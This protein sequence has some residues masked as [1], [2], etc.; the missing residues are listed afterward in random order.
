MTSEKCY[1][2]GR[3]LNRLQELVFSYNGKPG[4]LAHNICAWRK[5]L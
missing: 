1:L 5:G 3:K 4:K 2:C